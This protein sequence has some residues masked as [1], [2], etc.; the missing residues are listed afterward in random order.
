MAYI[1][2]CKC[3]LAYDPAPDKIFQLDTE[4]HANWSQRMDFGISGQ[5][6]P[7]LRRIHHLGHI[8]VCRA[9]KLIHRIHW[10]RNLIYIRTPAD[11]VV[12]RIFYSHHM[13]SLSSHMDQRIDQSDYML[14]IHDS[15]CLNCIESLCRWVWVMLYRI[16]DLVCIQHLHD[17]CNSSDTSI[18]DDVTLFYIVH[19]CHMLRAMYKDPHR[20]FVSMLFHS[21]NLNHSYILCLKV[22]KRWF[23]LLIFKL[24]ARGGTKM[25]CMCVYLEIQKYRVNEWSKSDQT[26]DCKWWDLESSFEWLFSKISG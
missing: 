24:Y 1:L 8:H 10:Q 23:G 26:Y 22:Q 6:M 16:V 18:V 25:V 11:G 12:F 20:Y 7:Y 13:Q 5:C 15:Q 19:L 3:K 9:H 4:L 17:R 2:S 14:M 21:G